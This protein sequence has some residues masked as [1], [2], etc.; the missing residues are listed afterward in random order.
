MIFRKKLLFIIAILLLIELSIFTY[1]FLLSP[2]NHTVGDSL[3]EVKSGTNID[4][5]VHNLKEEDY[6]RS[7]LAFKLH[8]RLNNIDNFKAG[9]YK[10]DTSMNAKSI[11]YKLS[12]GYSIE[13]NFKVT[14]PEGKTLVEMADIL[15]RHT[16]FTKEEIVQAWNDPD[17]IDRVIDEFD[18]VT[19]EIKKTGISYPLNGYFFPDTYYI[20]DKDTPPQ[21]IAL[22]LL[23]RMEQMILPYVDVIHAKNF[24]VHEML[25]LASI[26]EYEAKWDEDPP[27]I[28]G[29]FYNRLKNNMKLESC[30]TLEMALGVHKEIYTENDIEV[31]SPYNTYQVSGIPIGPGNNPGERSIEACLF[32]KEHDYFYFLSDIYGDN[33]TYYSKTLKEHNTLKAK[34]LSLY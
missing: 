6:I 5:I 2:T 16:N 26:V 32:P 15:S 17:F 8:L 1:V 10:L 9:D 20:K 21:D 7:V 33:K 3:F 12:Q 28:A 24:S 13:R 34:Y 14:F 27:I 18:F 22:K 31:N 11:A 23:Q 25:T 19:E 4:T 30:A 29:V